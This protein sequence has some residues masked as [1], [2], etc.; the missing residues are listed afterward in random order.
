MA[1]SRGNAR[2]KSRG[3][4]TGDK[5]E[6]P[7]PRGTKRQAGASSDQSASA[8]TTMPAN[9]GVLTAAVVRTRSPSGGVRGGIKRI[10]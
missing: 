2:G 10:A 9:V 7:N 8:S 4:T 3:T 5:P 1:D 6:S